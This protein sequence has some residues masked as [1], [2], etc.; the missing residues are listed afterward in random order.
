[1]KHGETLEQFLLR[2]SDSLFPDLTHAPNPQT[3][4][5]RSSDGDTPLHI[6]ALWG[7]RHAARILLEAGADIDA[8]GDMGCTPLYFSVMGSYVQVAELLLQRGADPDVE[9][10]LGFSPRSLAAQKGDKAMA[11]LFRDVRPKPRW[12][13][14]LESPGR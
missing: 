8:K 5:S 11:A 1:M 10:E 6:A 12:R 9:S 3:V 13:W 2:S 7:D 14:S 4:R